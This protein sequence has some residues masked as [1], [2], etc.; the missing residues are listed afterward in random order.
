M[1]RLTS[2]GSMA[3]AGWRACSSWIAW[4]ISGSLASSCQAVARSAARSAASRAALSAA[5][6]PS[7]AARGLMA[8][9]AEDVAPVVEQ[10]VEHVL[11]ESGGALDEREQQPLVQ[12][13]HVQSERRQRADADEPP[14]PRTPPGEHLCH[15]PGL[16]RLPPRHVCRAYQR[17]PAAVNV[18][19]GRGPVKALRRLRAWPPRGGRDARAARK[20]APRAAVRCTPGRASGAHP[21]RAKAQRALASSAARRAHQ[22]MLVRPSARAAPRDD[23]G[24]A[25]LAAPALTELAAWPRL[26]GD[27]RRLA[28]VR[29]LTERERRACE[30]EEVLSWPRS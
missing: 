20:A 21:G 30:F 29:L 24:E 5:A 15:H 16:L 9:G 18:A 22:C 3:S 23:L 4:S 19:R 17:Q 10:F 26:L 11:V 25:W 6:R 7:G 8:G 14:A 28:L 1:S 2:G 27:P 13:Q 12:R